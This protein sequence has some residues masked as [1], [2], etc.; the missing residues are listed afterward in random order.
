MNIAFT[1]KDIQELADRGITQEKILNQ[2]EIF[3]EGIPPAKLIKPCTIGDGITV[4][5][6]A[7]EKRLTELYQDAAASGR[8]M[9]FVPA[10]GAATRMFHL[11]LAVMRDNPDWEAERLQKMAHCNFSKT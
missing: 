3:K 10:S 2:I 4:I 7:E 8:T 6:S 11:L 9:K 1:D 5:S